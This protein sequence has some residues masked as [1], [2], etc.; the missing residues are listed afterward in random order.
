MSFRRETQAAIGGSSQSMGGMVTGMNFF[1]NFPE[2]TMTVYVMT[3]IFLVTIAN[4]IAGRI[5]YGGDRY[6]FYLFATL[7]FSISGALAIAAPAIVDIFFKISLP[8]A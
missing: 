3:I 2:A 6:I 8:G 1:V 5:V 7:L 4:I